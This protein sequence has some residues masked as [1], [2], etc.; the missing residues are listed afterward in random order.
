MMKRSML[1]ILALSVMT[2]AACAGD[3]DVEDMET[4]EIPETVEPVTPAPAPVAPMDTT[5]PMD[6]TGMA[7]ADTTVR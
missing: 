1:W 4:T 7:P 3:D 5:M 2:F 6:T